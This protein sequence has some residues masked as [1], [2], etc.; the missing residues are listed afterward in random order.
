LRC[1]PAAL[2]PKIL[3]A[4]TWIKLA[5]DS[6]RTLALVGQMKLEDDGAIDAAE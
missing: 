2:T 5:Q 3:F 6:E 1:T 4:S